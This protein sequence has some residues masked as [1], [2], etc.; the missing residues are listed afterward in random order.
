[1]S[2]ALPSFQKMAE[3]SP[4]PMVIW[5]ESGTIYEANEAFYQLLGMSAGLSSAPNYW[6]LTPAPQ[7]QLEINHL[8]SREHEPYEKELRARSGKQRSVRVEGFTLE[9]SR[10][11]TLFAAIMRPLRK[12]GNLS[13]DSSLATSSDDGLAP[14]SSI[15]T[16]EQ[17]ERE[18]V[19]RRQNELLF[20]LAR[21][22][23]VSSGD[24]VAAARDITE[25]AAHGMQVS[26]ASIWV[27]DQHRKRIVCQVLYE[28]DSGRHNDR[29]VGTTLLASEYPAY[30]RTLSEERTVIADDARSHPATHEFSASY[31]EPLG[32]HSMLEAPLRHKGEL[33]GVLCHEQCHTTRSWTQDDVSFAIHLADLVERAMEA[34]DRTVVERALHQLNRELEQRIDDRARQLEEA[35]ELV[36]RLQKERTEAQMAAGFAQEML[37]ALNS[38]RGVINKVLG[39]G[40]QADAEGDEPAT[41][42]RAELQDLYAKL[43]ER[44]DETTTEQFALAMHHADVLSEAFTA[45][46]RPVE[47]AL[48]ITRE[49]SEYSLIGRARPGH[50]ICLMIPLIQS[51]HDELVPLIEQNQIHVAFDLH[52]PLQLYGTELHYRAAIRNLLVNAC[53]ALAELSD[54]RQ[55]RVVLRYHSVPAGALI[56]VEDNGDGI[57]EDVRQR[58][59]E[60]FFST[61]GRSHTGLG[62]PI[63]RKVATLY[64]GQLDIDSRPGEGTRARILLPLKQVAPVR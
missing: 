29:A 24:F 23:I 35:T 4:L 45:L 18:R 43:S 12:R 64:D 13:S 22:P 34:V 33:V 17:G 61:K 1:M 6:E 59:F 5:D 55:R 15:P 47:Q 37:S 40:S 38:A 20:R 42:L 30:F 14:L 10:E 41:Q 53:D 28:L 21:S 58:L 48:K 44:L 3:V 31:L 51:I 63:V 27:F 62:L 57:P 19:L 2:S 32:I 54:D 46:L 7:K 11:R 39:R 60:P 50:E 8:L 26:R 52:G 25:V 49:I 9:R 16:D 36:L 56:S